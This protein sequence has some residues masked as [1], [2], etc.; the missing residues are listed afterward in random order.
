M[1][2]KSK[3]IKVLTPEF[4]ASYPSIFTPKKN[5]LNGK[6]EYSVMALF[7]KDADL[8]P[9]F[10]AAKEVTESVWGKDK[11]KWPKNLKDP[12]K[13]QD[14]TKP[15]HTEGAYFLNIKC[16]AS[17]NVPG[18]LNAKKVQIIDPTE[19]YGGCYGRATI[20]FFAYD[21]PAAKGVSMLLNN[22]QKT[23]DGDPFGNRSKPEDDF[24]AFG[25]DESDQLSLI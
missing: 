10:A 25:T 8:K 9:L 22:F 5:D 6:E 14:P 17:K 4:R 19:I 15:G 2:E 13:K 16:D 24:T 20:T 23:R 21:L 11:A 3:L 1:S 12:F 18:V 7:P